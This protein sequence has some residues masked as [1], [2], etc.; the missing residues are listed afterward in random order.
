MLLRPFSDAT[1]DY[2]RWLAS[3]TPLVAADLARKHE[4]MRAD[5]FQFLRATFY[6]WASWWPRRCAELSTRAVVPSVGDLHVQNFGTWR[7]AEGRLAWGVNDFDEARPLPWPQDLVR[8]ATSAHLAAE[9]GTLAGDPQAV[10]DALLGG[11]RDAVT[12]GGMPY[13][14]AEQHSALH[15]MWDAQRPDAAAFWAKLDAL[16][17]LAEGDDVPAGARRALEESLPARGLTP[18]VARRVAGLGSLG[19]TRLVAIVQ[20]QGGRVAREVK[21]I[22]PSAVLWAAGCPPRSADVCVRAVV[23][24]A[25]R[26]TDPFY[27]ARRRWMIRRLAPDMRRFDLT[28]LRRRHDERHLLHA[29]GWETANVHLGGAAPKQLAV[30]LRATE[31]ALGSR[32]LPQ[33]VERMTEAVRDDFAAWGAAPA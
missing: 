15:D 4:Q 22:A 23:E 2:E 14:L 11:Y 6:R 3:Y 26:C 31:H 17:P 18:R 27:L 5:A 32:W 1:A 13:V 7:D 8:L 10:A 20:W 21:A 19:R 33:A 12:A 28:D 29:M 16:P 30:E 25:V 24:G 9:R